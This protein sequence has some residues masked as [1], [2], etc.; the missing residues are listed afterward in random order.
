MIRLKDINRFVKNHHIPVV[1][2]TSII[3]CILIWTFLSGDRQ[4]A[5]KNI[6]A[7]IKGG[8]NRTVILYDY[9]GKPIRTWKGKINV[10]RSD[11][12]ISM[13]VNEEHRIIIHGGIVVVEE[14]K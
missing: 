5:L 6:E 3:I 7:N 13:I 4:I 10:A 1:L 12:E 14:H 9:A 11:N 2:V 8:L